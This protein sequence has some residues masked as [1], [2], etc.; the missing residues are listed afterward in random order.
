MSFMLFSCDREDQAIRQ[1]CE[2]IHL[3]YPMA[4]LQDVYKT[5]YQDFFGAEHLMNDTTMARK[6][7]HLELEQCRNTDLSAMPKREPTGFRHRF[8]RINFSCI[9]DEEL[10]EEQLL[11]M[12][13]NAAGKDNALNDNWYSEWL[14]VEAV[15]LSINPEWGDM[16]LMTE[17]RDAAYGNLAVRHS[18]EFRQYYN[19]HYRIVRN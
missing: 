9:T 19:P 4:T 11:T 17:L 15:A 10:T 5:C 12:F 8:I 1:M 13:V 14:K 3:S 18:E 16:A 6:Y 7:I 2:M